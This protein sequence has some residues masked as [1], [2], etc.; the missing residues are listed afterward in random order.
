MGGEVK[1]ESCN[2]TGRPSK[3]VDLTDIYR[4]SYYEIVELESEIINKI[5]TKS[6]WLFSIV[7]VYIDRSIW[8]F[9]INLRQLEKSK[10]LLSFALDK[11][12]G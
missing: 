2:S 7:I 12:L 3:L 11:R 1:N 4:V 10:L 6:N 8:Q 9:L 5:L